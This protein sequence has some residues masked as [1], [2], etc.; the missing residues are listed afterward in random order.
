MDEEMVAALQ[1]VYRPRKVRTLLV[2]ESPSA[3]GRFFYLGNS[4]LF[5]YT[6]LAFHDVF[7]LQADTAEEFLAW[8]RDHGFFLDNLAQHS[9]GHLPRPARRAAAMLWVPSLAERLA[10]YRPNNLVAVMKSLG[11]PVAQAIE[12]ADISLE[13]MAVLPFPARSVRNQWAY[14]EQLG[15]LVGAWGV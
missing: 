10:I 2:A 9:I 6:Y 14:R 12:L 13:N 11:R 1:G 7:G 8:F 4:P 5:R 15:N 3:A